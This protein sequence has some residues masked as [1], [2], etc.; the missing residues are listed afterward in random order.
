MEMRGRVRRPQVTEVRGGAL[1]SANI[2]KPIH[3]QRLSSP[4][5][6]HQAEAQITICAKPGAHRAHTGR[7]PG[8][9]QAQ[10]KN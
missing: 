10:K 3:I 4:V 8:V 7:T 9:R 5:L 1:V 6:R 2:A